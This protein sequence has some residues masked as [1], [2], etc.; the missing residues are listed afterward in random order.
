[1]TI[2]QQRIA[3]ASIIG[4]KDNDKDYPNDANTRKEM[5]NHLTPKQKRKLIELLIVGAGSG[6]DWEA[7]VRLIEF[8][9]PTFT[10]HWLKVVGRW[11]EKEGDKQ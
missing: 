11:S 9:Q 3:V 6:E 10:K 1:M 7:F 5:W 4:G 2:E 8:D